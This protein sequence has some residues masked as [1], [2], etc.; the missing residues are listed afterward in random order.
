MAA[1]L[2]PQGQRNAAVRRQCLGSPHSG[3]TCLLCQRGQRI[4]T[5]ATHRVTRSNLSAGRAWGTRGP[6]GGTRGCAKAARCDWAADAR[7]GPL[8]GGDG[9]AS[10]EVTS[11]ST[12]YRRDATCQRK[13]PCFSSLSRIVPLG[14]FIGRFLDDIHGRT[15]RPSVRFQESANSLPTYELRSRGKVRQGR[16]SYSRRQVQNTRRDGEGMGNT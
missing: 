14:R 3:C 11:S 9:R 7:H 4:K 5:A 8:I 13:S 1:T 15:W 2:G 16:G 6:S 10:L 12:F